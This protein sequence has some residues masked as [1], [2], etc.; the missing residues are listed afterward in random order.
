M[1]IEVCHDDQQLYLTK[2]KRNE[3]KITLK[4][5]WETKK[6]KLIDLDSSKDSHNKDEWGYE[7]NESSNQEE[8]NGK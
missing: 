1:D 5:P 8:G 2:L 3:H 4:N 7:S 6:N